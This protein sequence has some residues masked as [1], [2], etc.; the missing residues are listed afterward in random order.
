MDCT[1]IIGD[2]LTIMGAFFMAKFSAK[3]KLAAVECYL[4]GNDGYRMI[5]ASIGAASSLV[6]TWV[7][8]YKEIGVEAFEKSYISYSTQ[9]KLFYYEK[10]HNNK[11][12]IFWTSS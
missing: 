9:F 12:N 10:I 1:R 3:D 2:N 4:Q 8:Q 6:I 5:G 7:K 11:R